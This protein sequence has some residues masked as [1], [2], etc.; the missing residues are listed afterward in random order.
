MTSTKFVV[1]HGVYSSEFTL[2]GCSD[3]LVEREVK[4][5]LQQPNLESF[6]GALVLCRDLGLSLDEQE[7]GGVYRSNLQCAKAHPDYWR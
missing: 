7:L 2:T 6:E 1:T 3:I 4:Y 5:L